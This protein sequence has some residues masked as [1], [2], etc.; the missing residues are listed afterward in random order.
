[1]QLGDLVPDFELSNQHGEKIKLSSYRGK[2]NV[3]I[4]FYPAAFTGTCTGELCAL[5]DDLADFNNE[6]VELLA[7]SCDTAFTLKAFA[8]QEK[9]D[10]NLLSDF[11]PH[12][13]VCKAY[14]VFIPERGFATRGTFIVN[15]EGRLHWSI[16]TSPAE[17]RSIDDYKAALAAL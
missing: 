9:Y 17:S 16:V 2:K 11:W 15:K 13:E 14:D 5:R 10:F 3:V 12:G 8:A 4:V 6:K 1:M 7:I